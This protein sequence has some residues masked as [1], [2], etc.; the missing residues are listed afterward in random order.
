MGSTILESKLQV[1][2]RILN[3]SIERIN[4]SFFYKISYVEFRLDKLSGIWNE[5]NGNNPSYRLDATV[6]ITK[7][8][9][10][11]KK[12]SCSLCIQRLS[13]NHLRV[14]RYL[15]CV[16]CQ[17]SFVFNRKTQK[18]HKN[19]NFNAENFTVESNV[20]LTH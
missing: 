8:W 19:H 11:F 14:K 15:V 12:W 20:Y 7:L 5:A 13:F 6:T 2:N 1:S 10:S 4:K 9:K 3:P 16:C 18:S 17:S